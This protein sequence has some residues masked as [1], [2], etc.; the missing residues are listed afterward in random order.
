ML[1]VQFSPDTFGFK[2]NDDTDAQEQMSEYKFS[3]AEPASYIANMSQDVFYNAILP[4]LQ[5]SNADIDPE[6]MMD[7]GDSLRD[8]VL[9]LGRRR[10]GQIQDAR[11]GIIPFEEYSCAAADAHLKNMIEKA[12][13]VNHC[14]GG[15]PLVLMHTLLLMIKA[16]ETSDLP[17][18]QSFY[19]NNPAFS[20]PSFNELRRAN[21]YGNPEILPPSIKLAIF[22]CKYTLDYLCSLRQVSKAFQYSIDNHC[23]MLPLI[24]MQQC[25][26]IPDV[27]NNSAFF[28][29]EENTGMESLRAPLLQVARHRNKYGKKMSAAYTG[30]KVGVGGHANRIWARLTNPAIRCM[31]HVQWFNIVFLLDLVSL[32][33]TCRYQIMHAFKVRSILKGSG[34]NASKNTPSPQLSDIIIDLNMVDHSVSNASL[35]QSAS[36]DQIPVRFSPYIDL[37]GSLVRGAGRKYYPYCMTFPACAPYSPMECTPPQNHVAYLENYYSPFR[38]PFGGPSKPFALQEMDPF[39]MRLLLFDKS[40][41]GKTHAINVHPACAPDNRL[42]PTYKTQ[43]AGDFLVYSH[44]AEKYVVY[45]VWMYYCNAI[46][47]AILNRVF[48]ETHPEINP[49]QYGTYLAYKRMSLLNDLTQNAV[50]QI[51]KLFLMGLPMDYFFVPSAQAKNASKQDND[52]TPMRFNYTD[53]DLEGRSAK[54]LARTQFTGAYASFFLTVMHKLF[55]S[56]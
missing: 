56:Q 43:H 7:L 13:Y 8:A 41:P 30:N 11:Q 37:T 14:N 47:K 49:A 21:Y 10:I 15:L 19:Q 48:G 4:C 31:D 50:Q 38:A 27:S 23:A 39:F 24:T 29:I 36:G 55:M 18:M 12:T 32:E 5:N 20:P 26:L 9:A 52:K 34:G 35:S 25:G 44:I 46:L 53:A 16:W 1:R 17:Y 45:P 2:I 42:A 3:L 54:M 22:A 6:D 51:N 28:K 33:R 40:F